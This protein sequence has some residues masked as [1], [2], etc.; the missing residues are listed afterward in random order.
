MTKSRNRKIN[1]EQLSFD[2]L[3]EGETTLVPLPEAGIGGELLNILSKGLYTNP[4]DA[5]REYVQNSIDA[6]ADEVE[7]Q[8]TGNS[9]WILDWGDGM[10]R[11]EL[12][13]AREFGVS[14]KSIEENVGFRGIGIY[15]GFDLCERL[16]IRTKTHL[17]DYEHVLEFEF[18]KMRRFL[19]S[20]RL[21]PS[22]PAIPLSDL[23]SKNIYYRFERSSQANQGSFTIIQLEDLSNS[24]I[25]KLS[26]VKE[27][28][29]YIL[30]NLPVRFN[31]GFKYADRIENELRRNVPGYKSARIVLRI[32]N[33]P[34]VYVE[35]PNIEKLEDPVTGFITDSKGK[36]LAFYWACLTSVSEAISSRKPPEADFAGLVYKLKGFTIGDR[37]HLMRHFTR[38][39]LY[40]WWTG[41][42][43]I[44]NPEIIPTSA[45]D[46]FEAGPAKD[47]LEAAVRDV[48]S[49]GQSSLQKI[50]LESQMTRRADEIV[51]NSEKSI[52]EIEVQI[53][54]GK[55]DE[56]KTYTE[57]HD[58]IGNLKQQ[59]N[60]ASDKPKA[61]SLLKR[62]ESLQR[63]AKKELDQPSS[64]AQREK[65]PTPRPLPVREP[66]TETTGGEPVTDSGAAHPSEELPSEEPST[67]MA[68]LS[69]KELII[70]SGWDIPDDF[71]PVMELISEAISDHMGMNSDTFRSFLED[72]QSR[73]FDLAEEG[74]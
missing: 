66:E 53:T 14:Y 43:Y 11:D 54:S 22:R 2:D 31:T 4:L 1:A 51:K 65:K 15:S 44:T 48:F 18:G 40:T 60:K 12:L 69:L 6:N 37:Q 10:A 21:D 38:K 46:D 63:K 36:R 47:A 33:N 56:F 62:A 70:N 19:D 29:N 67:R 52:D 42:I 35:K 50:A 16:V 13:Q 25:H 64:G 55:Y 17:D 32:E 8:I 26:D 28:T 73:L 34:P 39:Q 72:V 5:I 9:V 7:I 61:N 41:E 74:K 59:K 20:A 30:R 57:L 49:G 27:M 58:I 24:H 45:R 71:L 3:K 23:L 68:E